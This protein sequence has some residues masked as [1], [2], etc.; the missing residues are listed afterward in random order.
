METPIG[1]TITL[2][3]A[4]RFAQNTLDPAV[5]ILSSPRPLVIGHR[6]CGAVAPEN[7]IPSFELALT[8]GADLVELDYHHT[9]DGVPVVI[10]DFTLDRT[11]DA[12]RLWGGSGLNVANRTAEELRALDA[13]GWFASHYAGARLPTLVEALE[14]IQA[15]GMALIERKGGQPA[16]ILRLIREK[17]WVN[18]LIV[19]SFDWEYLSAFHELEPRQV[20]GALG[21]PKTLAD[22]RNAT[23][24]SGTLSGRWIDELEK[25]GARIAVWN[26]AVSRKSVR[27]SHDRGFKVWVY[28][29]NDSALANKLLDRG[30]D[31]IITDNAARMFRTLVHRNHAMSKGAD[32]R[33]F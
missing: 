2:M 15:Q 3:T 26:K 9:K 21:P 22:G 29:V 8:A 19:Q 10:H 28:T 25:T 4:T 6:G 16:T 18:R 1:R 27:L 14:V 17:G 12:K 5:E 13:G 31:G 33:I 23:K 30:V 32:S 20:L 24:Y 11:T 7:T